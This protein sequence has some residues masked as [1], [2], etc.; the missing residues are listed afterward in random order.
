MRAK[1]SGKLIPCHD[2]GQPVSFSAAACPQCGSQE[3]SGP[4]VLSRKQARHHGLEERNDR[5]LVVVAST[6]GAIGA[7]YGISSSAGP[8]GATFSAIGYGFVG[9]LCGVAIAFGMNMTRSLWR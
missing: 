3:P 9:V 6:L 2:C 5:N 4:Y 8:V 1:T 7:L